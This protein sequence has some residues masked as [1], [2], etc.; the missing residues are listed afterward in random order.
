MISAHGVISLML[1]MLELEEEG[2]GTLNPVILN[3]RVGW[4]Q[5]RYL[6]FLIMVKMTLFCLPACFL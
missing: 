4:K 3:L 6:A 1:H 5:L 2:E